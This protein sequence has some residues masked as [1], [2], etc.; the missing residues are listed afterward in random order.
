[1]GEAFSVLNLSRTTLATQRSPVVWS[2]MQITWD[3]KGEDEERV[4]QRV[5][6]ELPG[7]WRRAQ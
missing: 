1:M 4:K 7:S 6:A 3:V 5:R 2:F